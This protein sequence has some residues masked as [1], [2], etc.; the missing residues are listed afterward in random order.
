MACNGTSF[1]WPS[2]PEDLT[3]ETVLNDESPYVMLAEFKNYL[4][5]T[6]CGENLAFYTAVHDYQRAVQ[7]AFGDL[8]DNAVILSS[9]YPF[10]FNVAEEAW[11]TPHEKVR[12]DALKIKFDTII[13][14]H[15][16]TNAVQEINIRYDIRDTLLKSNQQDRSYHPRLLTPSCDA[17]VELMRASSFI[18]FAANL[19]RTAS[20]PAS[21]ST[22]KMNRALYQSLR[23]QKSTPSM[24]T[25]ARVSSLREPETPSGQISTRKLSLSADSSSSRDPSFLHKL[26]TSMGFFSRSP[27]SSH[28]P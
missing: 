8:L 4:E 10:H 6:Y 9:G 14:Q 15:I 25:L 11:L 27:S 24:S 2:M 20:A 12:F 3:L 16:L 18:P 28:R 19:V 26:A 13:Q 17:V 7:A 21:P 22:K 5:K 23:R 1:P